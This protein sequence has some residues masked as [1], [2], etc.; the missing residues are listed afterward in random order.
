ML[1]YVKIP[2][3]ILLPPRRLLTPPLSGAKSYDDY[4]RGRLSR[5]GSSPATW[6]ARTIANSNL[7]GVKQPASSKMCL[8]PRAC[9]TSHTC[10]GFAA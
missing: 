4:S 6:A 3:R 5:S 1:Y 2:A 10:V 9:K 7:E 8:Q